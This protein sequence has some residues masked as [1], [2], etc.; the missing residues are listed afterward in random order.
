MALPLDR[1]DLSRAVKG[2]ASSGDPLDRLVA[3]LQVQAELEALGAEVVR[4]YVAKARAAGLSWARIGEAL[5]VTKQAVQQRFADRPA[6]GAGDGGA[7]AGGRAAGEDGDGRSS[8][9]SA[10]GAGRRASSAALTRAAVVARQGGGRQVEPHHVLVALLP[11]AQ[12][13]SDLASAALQR[14][15]VDPA[16]ARDAL[17]DGDPVGAPVTGRTTRTTR[18]P[19]VGVTLLAA[20]AIASARGAAAADSADLL[21][22][23][24]AG[25]GDDRLGVDAAA[26]SDEVARLRRWG[27][28]DA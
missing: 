17:A 19:E 5:G 11:D 15:G 6:R 1:K 18:S 16:A 4:R 3:A 28:A 24:V 8:R 26:V 2:A 27:F 22:A 14:L 12:G 13:P 21:V 7:D 10:K 20:A 23:L 25:T 9:R